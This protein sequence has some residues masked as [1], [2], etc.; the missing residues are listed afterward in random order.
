[1]QISAN[2]FWHIKMVLIHFCVVLCGALSVG[3]LGRLYMDPYTFG[4]SRDQF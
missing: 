1:V 3:K 2:S 4:G